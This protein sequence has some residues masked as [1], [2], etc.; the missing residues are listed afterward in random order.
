MSDEIVVVVGLQTKP[1]D[2][3]AFETELRKLVAT[4][5]SEDGCLLFAIHRHA[6]DATQYSAVERWT[7]RADLDNHFASPHVR[8]YFE[9]TKDLLAEPP[10]INVYVACPEGDPDKGAL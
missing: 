7:S 8:E 6:E 3:A 5:H 2:E 4:T 1:G 10:T 9:A